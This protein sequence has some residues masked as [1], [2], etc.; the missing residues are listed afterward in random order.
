M[1]SPRLALAALTVPATAKGERTHGA[2]EGL[3]S[4]PRYLA[5]SI[6]APEME[7]SGLVQEEATGNSYG[8]NTEICSV[9]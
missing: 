9:N 3:P 6:L 7:H 8:Y 4:L 2:G 5:S 1:P